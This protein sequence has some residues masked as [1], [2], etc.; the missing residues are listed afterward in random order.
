MPSRAL[1][2]PARV[3]T[4]AVARPVIARPGSATPAATAPRRSDDLA[5]EH[6][7][8][9]RWWRHADVAE[10]DGTDLFSPRDLASP[11]AALIAGDIPRTPVMLGL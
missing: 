5:A 3:T 6:I 8:E 1:R 4:A 7:S 9:M 10:Y 11:L 2:V